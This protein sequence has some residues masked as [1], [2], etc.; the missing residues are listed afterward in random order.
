[1]SSESRAFSASPMVYTPA[2][3]FVLGVSS[4]NTYTEALETKT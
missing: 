1:M 4:A 3:S 2:D